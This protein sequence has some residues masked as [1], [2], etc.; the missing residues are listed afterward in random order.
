MDRLGYIYKFTCPNGKYYIGH[1]IWRSPGMDPNYQ[2]SSKNPDYWSDIEKYGWDSFDKMIISDCYNKDELYFYETHWILELDALNPNKGYN[3]VL[4]TEGWD[5]IN[6]LRFTDPD[7]YKEIK[8]K[9][10]ATR[11]LNNN[12][13]DFSQGHTPEAREKQKA[14]KRIRGT[15]NMSWCNTPEAQEKARTTK[16]ER[17]GTVAPGVGTDEQK[18]KEIATKRANGSY[19]NMPWN[20]DDTQEKAIRTKIEKYGTRNP[21]IH[22]PEAERKRYAKYV[23]YDPDKK[24]LKLQI[25]NIAAKCYKSWVKLFKYDE[26]DE[27]ITSLISDKIIITDDLLDQLTNDHE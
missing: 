16:L 23:F 20:S 5:C 1:H 22:T 14:T 24:L 6:D 2:G 3:L 17:Y 25:R 7:H 8:D 21:N 4:S 26:S 9:S 15:D 27:Y 13:G 18:S 12:Y 11:R 10:V 19:D